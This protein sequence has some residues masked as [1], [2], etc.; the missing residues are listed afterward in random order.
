MFL[1]SVCYPRCVSKALKYAN[2]NDT[3]T[4][5]KTHLQYFNIETL[6]LFNFFAL[7]VDKAIKKMNDALSNVL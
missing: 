2:T 6:H 1:L 7:F 3:L 5:N 4:M